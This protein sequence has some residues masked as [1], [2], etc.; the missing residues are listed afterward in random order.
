VIKCDFYHLSLLHCAGFAVIVAAGLFSTRFVL[1]SYADTTSS[2][3]SKLAR[4][5]IPSKEEMKEM[6]AIQ[7]LLLNDSE[8]RVRKI[9]NGN[10][11][12]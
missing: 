7:K 2:G 8:S 5:Y 6:D 12:L 1:F 3:V 4:N 10:T 9:L 11:V